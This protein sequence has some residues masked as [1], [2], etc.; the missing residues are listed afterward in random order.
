MVFLADIDDL[1][2]LKAVYFRES[3]SSKR[4]KIHLH[5]HI[6]LSIRDKPQY[7]AGLL[8]MYFYRGE[9]CGSDF[10]NILPIV[11]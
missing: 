4:D 9:Q 6:K 8:I 2:H 10:C 5:R 3:P 11:Q 7:P 1:S